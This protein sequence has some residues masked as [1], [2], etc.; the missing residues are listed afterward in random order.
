MGFEIESYTST[1]TKHKQRRVYDD[2]NDPQDPGQD[3]SEYVITKDTDYACDP[4]MYWCRH[5]NRMRLHTRKSHHLIQ[6]GTRMRYT[7][8]RLALAKYLH[9]ITGVHPPWLPQAQQDHIQAKAEYIA[10]LATTHKHKYKHTPTHHHL[11]KQ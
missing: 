4:R 11:I 2:R 3:W 7:A 5:T 8:S 9:K 1:N 10:A 6:L